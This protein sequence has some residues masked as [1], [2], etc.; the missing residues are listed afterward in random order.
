MSTLDIARGERGAQRS[1]CGM[2]VD[3]RKAQY[4]SEFVGKTFYFCCGGCKQTIDQQSDKYV[5]AMVE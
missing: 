2:T 5:L 4:K 3:I 1:I